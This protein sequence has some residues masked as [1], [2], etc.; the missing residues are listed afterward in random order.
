MLWRAPWLRQRLL[1][2]CCAGWD[3]V[4]LYLSYNLIYLAR[5]ERWEGITLGLAV[6]TSLWLSISY[7]LGRYSPPTEKEKELIAIQFFKTLLVGGFIIAVFVGHSWF[8]QIVEA[9]TRF[10]GF[11]IPVVIGSCL[12]SSLG[13]VLREGL[14]RKRCQWLLI[15]REGEKRLIERELGSEGVSI[16]SRT[17]LANNADVVSDGKETIG[18]RMGI[19]IGEFDEETGKRTQRLLLLR[20]RG[21]RVI[22]LLSW[23]EQELQ[24]IP[25]EL[26][27][28]RWLIQAEGFGLRPGSMSWR[29]KRLGDVVGSVT[30][31]ILTSPL[32]LVGGVMVWLEDQGPIFY[33]QKRS[34]L[35]GRP[36]TIWKLRSMRVNAEERGAQWASKGDQRVTRVGRLIRATRMDELPQLF[37]VAKGDLSLIGP[38]PE[39]PQIEKEL[40]KH[41]PNYKVRQWIRPGLSG[42]AQVCYP[43][44]ASIEDSRMK[45]SYDLYYLRNASFLL[46]VLITIKT[47]RLI[48]R[49]HGASPT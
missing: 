5:L 44:G 48:A 7:L 6:I 22:P 13:Q 11:L 32:M 4:S 34:G 14:E 8:F 30:L 28:G 3:A 35:Y 10:R 21:V 20:E 49:A 24:R 42:W 41:I 2:V 38:R 12:A 40:V 37:S 16:R 31:I 33:R 25:P 45:L 18:E 26:V 43:Y 15:A 46:D 29:V 19:A 47:I 23:C 36:I 1:L 39:R 9:K 27:S 17:H